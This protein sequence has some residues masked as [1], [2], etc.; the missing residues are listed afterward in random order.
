MVDECGALECPDPGLFWIEFTEGE[1][2]D[3]AGVYCNKHTSA[4]R[5]GW[6]PFEEYG[7]GKVTILAVRTLARQLELAAEA[8]AVQFP[9]LNPQAFIGPNFMTPPPWTP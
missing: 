9:S 6:N 7:L 1:G 5:A 4:M 8:R 2:L 3:Y